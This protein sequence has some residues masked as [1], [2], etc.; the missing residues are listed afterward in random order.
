MSESGID[1]YE[2]PSFLLYD[3]VHTWDNPCDFIIYYVLVGVECCARQV[4]LLPLSVVNM[5]KGSWMMSPGCRLT[6]N[7]NIRNRKVEKFKKKL[8]RL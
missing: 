5:E 3:R 2:G 4:R 8:Q 1:V 6:I 7:E